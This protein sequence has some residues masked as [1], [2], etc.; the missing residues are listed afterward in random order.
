MLGVSVLNLDVILQKIREAYKRDSQDRSSGRLA[1]PT[2][3]GR[4]FRP[5]PIRSGT[6]ET[7]RPPQLRQVC[8]IRFLGA[9]LRLQLCQFRGYSSAIPADYIRGY[10]PSCVD[11]CRDL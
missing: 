8:P 2:C 11:N 9:E 4:S 1:E 3:P 7:D 6:A 10:L 5:S